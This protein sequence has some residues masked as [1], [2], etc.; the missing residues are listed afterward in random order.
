MKVQA[1]KETLQQLHLSLHNAITT[2]ESSKGYETWAVPFIIQIAQTCLPEICIKFEN[3]QQPQ[4]ESTEPLPIIEKFIHSTNDFII[5]VKTAD[6]QLQTNIKTLIDHREGVR[7]IQNQQGSLQ[8]ANCS[9]DPQYL[10][11]IDEQIN[12]QVMLSQQCRSLFE[13]DITR[14]LDILSEGSTRE[15]QIMPVIPP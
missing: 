9:V 14:L 3:I 10:L 13:K 12:Q 8:S 15:M 1:I 11:N 6:K 4:E 2:I 7:T 5:R